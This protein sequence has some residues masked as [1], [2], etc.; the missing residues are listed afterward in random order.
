M[1]LV[2]SCIENGEIF[3]QDFKDFQSNNQIDFPTSEEIAVVYGPNGTGKTSLIKALK[4]IPNTKVVY[5]FDGVE[6]Q[7]G[8]DIFHI[9]CDQN[10]RNIIEG[11]TRDFFLGD[12]IRREFELQ[13]KV[14]S[15]RNNFILEIIAVLK[16][17]FG[18]SA[19]NS[20]LIDLVPHEGVKEFIKDCVN[21]KSK[22]KKYTTESLIELL[23]SLS[24]QLVSE[25]NAERLMFV[26]NDLGNKKSIIK[27][28]E[29]LV[30]TE[31]VANGHVYEIEENTEAIDILSRFHKSK[32]IVCDNEGID[33]EHLLLQKTDNRQ[34]TL[35]LLG[36][37]VREAIE[38]TINLVPEND[39]FSIK[40][41]LLDAVANGEQE[42]IISLYEEIKWYKCLFGIMIINKICEM[43]VSSD[44]VAHY[45]EYQQII[46]ES[47]EITE[48]DYLYIQEIISNSMSKPLTIERDT[49]RSL[50]IYLSNQE[51]LGRVRDEL[52][53]SA[54]E[55]NFLSLT[56][57]FLK[58]KNS[59]CPIVV[60]DDPISSFDSLYKNKVVY[61]IVKML[62]HK[63]RIVL[64][65]NTDLI[66]LLDGQ[67]RHC[68]K[69]YLLNNTDGELNGFIP[70][71]N[72]EQEMLISLEKLLAAFRGNVPSH[73]VNAELFLIAMIPFMRGYAN[74]I[75]NKELYDGLTQVMHGY[76]NENVDIANAYRELFGEHNE[77]LPETYQVS[78]SDILSKN[79]DGVELLNVEIFPLLNRTLRHSFVYLSLRLL[80]EKKLVEKYEINT[81]RC[82]QLGQ[83]IAAAYPSETDIE[84]IRNKI[85]LTSKKTLINEFNH[86]EG[87]LSIFQPAID[88]TDQALSKER[89][90]I[91]SLMNNI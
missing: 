91:I 45:R 48:E 41:E 9:I 84:Q 34:S 28:I 66:R 7:G 33:W 17:E 77:Y 44:L 32:C 60:I 29:Q 2:F 42:R 75:N 27:K 69:L 78:V 6:Y 82:K 65:H 64:T 47:P 4:D 56:F 43:V 26:Q 72:N 71:K 73:V 87:N 53:L 25:Y 1:S 15:D 46:A 79:V 51:F 55:Q 24:N 54:G 50:R 12:N 13:D 39:P 23:E 59:T 58:A 76:K 57:E 40:K 10:D 35:E 83:I 88:I 52:P 8:R 14:G 18:I 20:P 19:A 67:Y 5:S 70:L 31:I 16:T 62:H 80:V 22:G 3:T 74:I 11:E 85:I 90:D 86:F 63:K 38:Q 21:S 30:E 49:N 61:A 37:Q 81:S 89:E 68:F 36:E